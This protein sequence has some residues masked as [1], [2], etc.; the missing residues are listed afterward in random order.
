MK[1]I[2]Y[3][4]IHKR[5][6]KSMNP[7][8]VFDKLEAISMIVGVMDLTL[9]PSYISIYSYDIDDIKRLQEVFNGNV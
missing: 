6:E 3:Y 7:S 4:G 1:V 9:T 5:L 2:I 8:E